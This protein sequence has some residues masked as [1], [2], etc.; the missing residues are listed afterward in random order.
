[1]PSSVVPDLKKVLDKAKIKYKMETI[2]GTHHG[3]TSPERKDYNPAGAEDTWTKI[4]AMWER[5]LKK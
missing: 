3:F 1:V 5:N 2:P 4:F